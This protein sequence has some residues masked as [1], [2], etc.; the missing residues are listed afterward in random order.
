MPAQPVV[1]HNTTE[2]TVCLLRLLCACSAGCVPTQA[3]VCVPAQVAVCLLP[4][5]HD[6][7]DY[8]VTCL[9]HQAALLS[10]YNQLYRDTT[11]A[12]PSLNLS[13]YK[14]CIVAHSTPASP[15]SCHNTIWCIAT[16]FPN[17]QATACHDTTNCI[18]NFSQTKLHALLQYT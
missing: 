8:I 1:C 5:C 15:C 17:H 12:K 18:V 4:P 13:R 9:S 3:A 7:I 10:R 2:P 6:T 11:P 16:Q 14:I